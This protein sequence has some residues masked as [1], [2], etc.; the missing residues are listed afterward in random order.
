MEKIKK[1]DSMIERGGEGREI[2]EK[3]EKEEE[4]MQENNGVVRKKRIAKKHETT[5][6]IN[7]LT[8][9]VKLG[10]TQKQTV[11]RTMRSRE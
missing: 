10:H 8:N 7:R 3:T 9:S 1:K 2:N 4:E 5:K 11:R 6:R